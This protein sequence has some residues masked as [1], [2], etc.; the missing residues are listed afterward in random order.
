MIAPQPLLLTIA[1]KLTDIS[2]GV[3]ETAETSSQELD[4][5]VLSVLSGVR[6]NDAHMQDASNFTAGAVD[7]SEAALRALASGS[8]QL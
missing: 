3:W 2:M 5:R 6:L 7:Q 4:S 8:G 1:C